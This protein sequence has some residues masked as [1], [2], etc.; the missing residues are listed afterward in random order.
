M[1]VGDSISASDRDLMKRITIVLAFVFA[2]TALFA[3]LE[4]TYSGKFFD[5]TGRAEWIWAQHP[6]N[7]NVP[8]AFFAAHDFDLPPQRLY[9]HLKILGDPE[10]TVYVNGREAGGRRLEDEERRLDLY[11]ISALVKTG[12]NRIVVAVR[13][14]LGV[15]GLIASIDIAPETENWV[16]T[17]ATW[18]IY[19]RWDPEI[20]VRD[21]ANA[22]P[23]APMLLGEPPVGRW[24]YLT[25][26]NASVGA[27]P[28]EVIEPVASFE[29]MG[30]IPII[31]TEAGISVATA[32]RER[33][34]AF[35]FKPTHGRLR[36]TVASD[37]FTSRLVNVR[38]ANLESELGLVESNLRPIVFAPGEHVV[39]TPESHLFRYAMAFG[40]NV[41]AE[42]V[43]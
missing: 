20:L 5:A 41:R 10:Y 8:V 38:F 15:G 42:V 16:V 9:T 43:R 3:F 17:D 2:F 11:D 25:T 34:T 28:A 30:L 23:Q 24:N 12:R 19:R 27:P 18:K 14:P 29:K 40:T 22:K 39:T 1:T 35:D 36:L 26:E 4:R 37:H 6:L 32:E 13:A 21:T 7:V 33:A 31:R